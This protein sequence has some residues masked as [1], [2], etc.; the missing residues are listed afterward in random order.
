MPSWLA[1]FG[2]GKK[3]PTTLFPRALHL[4]T[5]ALRVGTVRR[6]WSQMFYTEVCFGN[7]VELPSNGTSRNRR[8]SVAL[9]GLTLQP[10]YNESFLK[11][12]F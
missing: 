8:K 9:G 1:F 2:Q 3:F 11:M 7:T 4:Y 12:A 6:W 5:M 10:I